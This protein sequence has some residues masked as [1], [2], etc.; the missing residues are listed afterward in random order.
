MYGMANTMGIRKTFCFF[1]LTSFLLACNGS[2]SGLLQ[3]AGHYTGSLTTHAGTDFQKT[4]VS[5]Q[6]AA[7]KAGTKSKM[8]VFEDPA[9]A[10]SL[11]LELTNLSKTSVTLNGTPLKFDANSGCY[12][13]EASQHVELCVSAPEITYEIDDSEKGTLLSLIAYPDGTSR[14]PVQSETPTAF[15]LTQAIARAQSMSFQSKIE[16]E[17]V[18]QAR[19]TAQASY[20]HLLPQLTLSTVINAVTPSV[21]SLLADIGD[22]APFLF[23]SR[24]I[25]I[26]E[27]TDQSRAEQ[28]SERLMRL[29]M[30]TQVQGLFYTYDCDKKSQSIY[31]N[32]ET[33]V[34]A[35]LKTVHQSEAAGHLTP[36]SS[37]TLQ[38]AYNDLTHNDGVYDQILTQDLAAIAQALG[39]Y[40]PLAVSDAQIDAELNPIESPASIDYN[41]VNT[42]A[43]L[44]SVELDQLN[45]LIDEA[46]LTKKEEYFDWL[47]PA[48]NPELGLGAA[49][50]SQLIVAQSQVNELLITRDQIS[51]GISQSALDSVTDYNQA[52]SNYQ[53]SQSDI[54]LHEKRLSEVENQ[55][56]TGANV[57]IFDLCSVISD[58]LGSRLAIEQAR[59]DYRVARAE[60]DRLRLQSYYQSF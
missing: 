9:G 37:D 51:S 47:D 52:I 20:Q 21:S 32:F 57:D 5:S 18:I 33:R 27:T 58:D 17:H 7:S 49:L 43:Q 22:L 55:L 10:K 44:R 19:A 14:P 36:G 39:F 45:D 29:D 15:S 3:I 53:D 40:S 48:A 60:T 34:S 59:A 23:P 38:A 30:A 11:D 2:A 50:H 24:W 26:K 16:F 1:L 25:Q 28:D 56:S 4:A 8:I 13:T 6:I 42:D 54:L 31:K 46:K 35:I 12:S 41:T